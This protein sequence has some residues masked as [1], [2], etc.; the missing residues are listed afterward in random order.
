MPEEMKQELQWEFNSK[1]YNAVSNICF[2]Q[3]AVNGNNQ[4]TYKGQLVTKDEYE[5]VIE[6][7]Y[8]W[9]ITHFFEEQGI[10]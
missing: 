2:D 5:K 7:A 8:E 4:A 9:F 1:F 6:E 10:K 3:F